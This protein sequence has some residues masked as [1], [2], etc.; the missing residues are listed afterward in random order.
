MALPMALPGTAGPP[1]VAHSGTQPQPMGG[2]P[3]CR[4]LSLPSGAPAV[5]TAS[6]ALERFLKLPLEGLQEFL[7]DTLS[8]AWALEDDTVPRQLQASVAEL[9]RTQCDLF[10]RRWAQLRSPPKSP[11]GAV[12]SGVSP[13]P[14]SSPHPSALLL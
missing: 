2:A 5:L 4:G 7:Q 14:S 3:G 12:S 6:A 13:G 8:R 1:G 11:P 9:Y 10:P